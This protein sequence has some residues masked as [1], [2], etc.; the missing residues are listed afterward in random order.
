MWPGDP[1]TGFK[2]VSSASS[3][4]HRPGYSRVKLAVSQ[5]NPAGRL[6]ELADG[7]D[8]FLVVRPAQP[9]RMFHHFPETDPAAGSF[10]HVLPDINSSPVKIAAGQGFPP[11]F[12]S[13]FSSRF[14]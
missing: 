11:A 7:Q 1:R 2:P 9:F 14:Y 10:Y 13:A 4:V 8:P 6:P 12:P 5:Q 3:H